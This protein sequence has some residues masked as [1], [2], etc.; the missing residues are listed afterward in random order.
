M[1]NEYCIY[2][3]KK[4][5]AEIH[6]D[7][8][9]LFSKEKDEGFT[10]YVYLNGEISNETFIKVFD[11]KDAP[12]AHC[13]K[14]Q[15]KYMGIFF[16]VS[17]GRIYRGTVTMYVED[18]DIAAKCGFERYEKIFFKKRITG[19]EIEEIK[20]DDNLLAENLVD[21]AETKTTYIPKDKVIEWLYENIK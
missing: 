11:V 3:G 4:Y 6:A 18:D 7:T 13:L 20:I 19:E 9:Q 14:F 2:K 10:N 5:E 1:R 21:I 15:V 16:D 12:P 17:F 8:I